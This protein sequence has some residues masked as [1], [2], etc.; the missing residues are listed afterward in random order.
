M[1][2]IPLRSLYGLAFH[3]FRADVPEHALWK[4]ARVNHFIDRLEK[5]IGTGGFA[6]LSGQTGL[7]KS[8]VIHCIASTFQRK[9]GIK[10]GIMERPQSTMMDFYR[11]LGDVFGLSLAPANRY[12]SFR[13]LRQK[14]ATHCEQTLSHP[15]LLVDEAQEMPTECLT[16]LRLLSSEQFDSKNLLT[17]VLC[18]DTRLP[19][20]F[21]ELALMPLGSRI[22]VRL[23]LTL[24]SRDELLEFLNHQLTVAG[25]PSLMTDPLKETL[26]E[27]AGGNLRV[28]T[29]MSTDLLE[30]AI[31][32][33]L[34]QLDEKLYIELFSGQS[35]RKTFQGS[36]TGKGR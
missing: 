22:R 33:D 1:T 28:L 20:R 24:Y 15:L 35:V 10:V 14:W 26:V 2:E 4:H 18:G 21:R 6:L 5:M 30:E 8:K 36:A 31:T 13:S 34:K 23:L 16:E 27:H 32:R 29:N 19:D 7:G 17:V 12:G 3:P 9:D 11:E 25:A